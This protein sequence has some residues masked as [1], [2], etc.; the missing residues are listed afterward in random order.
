MKNYLFL[1]LAAISAFFPCCNE[2]VYGELVIFDG[3]VQQSS[4]FIG[5]AN[6]TT[7]LATFMGEDVLQFNP[8]GNYKSGGLQFYGSDIFTIPENHS[9]LRVTAYATDPNNF[10]GFVIN[11]NTGTGSFDNTNGSW[12][13]DGAPGVL[14]D[15]SAGAWHDLEFDLNT[16]AGFD[17]GTSEVGGFIAFKN[18]TAQ[19]PIYISD[20]RF[21]SAVPEPSSMA[22]LAIG[23]A[24]LAWHRRKPKKISVR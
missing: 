14:G 2:K 20:I 19:G 15:F 1:T 13:L 16:V 12:T 23:G 6:G 8:A 4:G 22:L 9:L 3:A 5:G 18:N 24:G 10:N 11:M 17:A 7:S 21:A